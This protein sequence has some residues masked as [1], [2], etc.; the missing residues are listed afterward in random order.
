M[1]NNAPFVRHLSEIRKIHSEISHYLALKCQLERVTRNNK[2]RG[3]D[4]QTDRQTSRFWHYQAEP[5]R[6]APYTV[7]IY[8]TRPSS[9]DKLLF[10]SWKMQE[11]F[12][13]SL[14]H[15]HNTF[16]S[17]DQPFLWSLLPSR[18]SGFSEETVMPSE[19]R[20]VLE[21]CSSFVS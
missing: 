8:K 19:I 6:Q 5:C 4:R 20:G 21:V 16:R 18:L 7:A 11:Q 10:H 15:A 1:I 2:T 3:V 12:S 17:L 13:A 14:R 9:P